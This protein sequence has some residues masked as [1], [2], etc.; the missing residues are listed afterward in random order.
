MEMRKFKNFKTYCLDCKSS[1]LQM[2]NKF[3]LKKAQVNFYLAK[4]SLTEKIGA[5]QKAGIDLNI[6]DL[7]EY[8]YFLGTKEILKRL[9]RERKYIKNFIKNMNKKEERKND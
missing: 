1:A 6:S 9:H 3:F 4:K 8:V 2:R 7:E 5:Y